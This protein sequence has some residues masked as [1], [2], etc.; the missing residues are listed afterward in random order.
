MLANLLEG[1]DYPA[2]NILPW[3]ERWFVKGSVGFI[4]ALKGRGFLLDSP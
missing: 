4:P 2:W 1:M 3:H